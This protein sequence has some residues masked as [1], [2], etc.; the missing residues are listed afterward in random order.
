MSNVSVSK[1]GSYEFDYSLKI[2]DNILIHRDFNVRKY[3][4]NFR[5]SLEYRELVD[6][7][8]GDFRS[9][10]MG[11]ITKVL[12]KASIEQCWDTY[13]PN[14]VQSFEESISRDDLG[15]SDEFLFEITQKI[16]NKRDTIFSC[17]FS[18]DPYQPKTRVK[19][20]IKEELPEILETIR[21]YLSKSEY[22]KK[23]GSVKLDR[24]NKL[25]K[26]ELNEY[27]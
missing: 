8:I 22:T 10:K 23:Y 24:L 27:K 19:I 6:E 26:R 16:G 1:V 15:K 21:F 14:R 25:S 20:D 7:L 4:K 13:N 2:N 9:G 17:K 18:G 5:E 12:K 11:L 3:N